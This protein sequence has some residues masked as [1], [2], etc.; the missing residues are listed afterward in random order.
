MEIKKV[1]T[2]TSDEI[3]NNITN[4]SAFIPCNIEKCKNTLDFMID[5]NYLTPEGDLLTYEYMSKKYFSYI[6]W[7][8]NKY[9]DE[10]YT[11]QEFKLKSFEDFLGDDLWRN[12]Y[13]I[14]IK[15]GSRED[16][17]F[18]ENISIVQK[19]H[20]SFKELVKEKKRIAHEQ[21]Q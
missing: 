1:T 20:I 19:R 17:L 5:N 7:H 14:E 16:Y 21:K 12:T 10:K 2:L 11:K 13:K 8:S 4:S 6:A 15:H 3:W 9:P 18:G